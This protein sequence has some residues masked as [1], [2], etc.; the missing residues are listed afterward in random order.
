MRAHAL[1]LLLISGCTTYG[2]AIESNWVSQKTLKVSGA[3]NQYTTDGRIEDYVVLKAA[4]RALEAG[5]EYFIVTSSENTGATESRTLNGSYDTTVQVHTY[6]GIYGSPTSFA[7]ATT[8]GGPQTYN[9]YKPGRDAVFVMFDERPKGFRPG[10]YFEALTVY[11]ELGPKYLRNFQP[12]IDGDKENSEEPP[13]VVEVV[14]AANIA[15]G[16]DEPAA[17][18]TNEA[19]Q[20]T[21]ASATRELPTLDE[22][23]RSLSANERAAL[24]SLPPADR[25]DSLEEIRSLRY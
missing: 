16:H 9:I 19:D 23:Y 21:Y 18:S 8:T 6:G 10:Q 12:I 1:L 7:T 11:N 3:G 25:A 20:P 2:N 13:I 22:I 24:N 15:S 17:D 14:E 5:Y 4:E